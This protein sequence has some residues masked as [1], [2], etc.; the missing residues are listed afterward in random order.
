MLLASEVTGRIVKTALQS[1]A[2]ARSS[3]PSLQ[4]ERAGQAGGR[5]HRESPGDEVHRATQRGVGLLGPLDHAMW[6]HRPFRADEWLLEVVEIPSR[7][8]LGGGL[9]RAHFFT[10]DDRLSR[11]RVKKDSSSPPL[12]GRH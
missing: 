6:F 11:P 8:A 1:F 3:S 7:L 5:F 12:T 10:R 4:T 2:S 9:V